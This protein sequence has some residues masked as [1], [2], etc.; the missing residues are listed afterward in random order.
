MAKRGTEAVGVFCRT[1]AHSRGYYSKASENPL[2]IVLLHCLERSPAVLVL[3][4]RLHQSIVLPDLNVTIQVVAVKGDRVR[5]G[6]EA[7]KDIPVMR[8]EL[9]QDQSE[10][11]VTSGRNANYQLSLV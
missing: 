2:L 6:I 10:A 3:T 8:E 11:P 5:L 4:R 7:P 1:S 9:L